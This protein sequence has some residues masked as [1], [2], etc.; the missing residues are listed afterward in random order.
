VLRMERKRL[1]YS[2]S[3]AKA[4]RDKGIA[5]SYVNYLMGL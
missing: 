3:L 4:Y 5:I 1:G 2:L